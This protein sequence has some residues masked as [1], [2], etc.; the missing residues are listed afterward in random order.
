M[1]NVNLKHGKSVSPIIVGQNVDELSLAEIILAKNDS[2]GTTS[3][4]LFAPSSIS[5]NILP[6]KSPRPSFYTVV[7]LNAKRRGSRDFCS[8]KAK[9]KRSKQFE[10]KKKKTA[11]T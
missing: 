11:Q 1:A 6:A 5:R 7:S 2:A 8:P 4:R 3:S 10:R 9:H